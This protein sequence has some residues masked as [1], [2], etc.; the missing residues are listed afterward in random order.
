PGYVWDATGHVA[1]DPNR[2]VQDAMRLIFGKFRETWSIRQTFKWFRDNH[3]DVPV[4]QARDGKLLVAFQRPRLSF[5]GAALHN[6]FYPGGYAWGRRA[7]EVVWDAGHLRKR[8]TTAVPPEQ[9]RVF[10][11]DHHEGYIDWPTFGENQ[12]MVRRNDFRG[13]GDDTAG[14]ARAGKG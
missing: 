6:P 4:T 12:R 1:K 8:Q 7:R 14:V 3:I 11:R 2:R 13:D 9:A 10:I 5:I